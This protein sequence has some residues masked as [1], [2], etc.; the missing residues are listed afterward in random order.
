MTDPEFFRLRYT[1]RVPLKRVTLLGETATP[2][3]AG[4]RNPP[5]SDG[6]VF[7]PRPFGDDPENRAFGYPFTIGATAGGLARSSV[8]AS[9]SVPVGTGAAAKQYRRLSLTFKS[10][11]RKGQGLRFGIDRDLAIS[12]FGGASDG[13]GA[14]ELGGATFYP[15]NRT[16][17]F[18]LT[19]MAERND[20]SR[21]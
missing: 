6:I 10:G 17:P 12:G 21:F 9:F 15:Q 11:L 18:G 8:A 7:D 13:K 14:D 19:L 5:M 16:I 20:G 3:A 2:T 4:K 1:G